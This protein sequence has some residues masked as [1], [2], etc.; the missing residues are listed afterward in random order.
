MSITAAQV[1]G[2]RVGIWKLDASHSEIGF[3]VRHLAISK[4]RGVFEAFDVTIVAPEDP[5]DATVEALIDVASVNTKQA[6]RDNHLRTSDFFAVD[7]HPNMRFVSTAFRPEPDGTF[8]LEGNLTLRG[9]TLPIV[10]TGATDGRGQVKAGV[11]AKTKI[12]RHDFGVS[13]SGPAE[14][15]GVTLGDE[16]AITFDLQFI[17]S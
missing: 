3:S 17:L 9:V 6:M 16:V 1:A 14:A 12:N 8:H 10:L 15:A 13:W 11:E 2:Y 5:N 4:V 7:E